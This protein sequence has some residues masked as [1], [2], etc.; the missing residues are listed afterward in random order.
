MTSVLDA[1]LSRRGRLRNA[2]IV[3]EVALSL[4]LLIGTGLMLR[5]F[6][7]LQRVRPGFDPQNVLT[8]N[9]AKS[10]DSTTGPPQTAEFYRQL[11]ERMKALPGV[12]NAS[13]VFQ[14]PLGGSG[15]TTS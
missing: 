14:L 15:G 1:R 9:V 6:T 12:I 10:V 4:V 2:L 11:T 8:F 5:S 3:G 7:N 13:V